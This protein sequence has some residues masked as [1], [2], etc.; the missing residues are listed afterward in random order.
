[1]SNVKTK[2]KICFQNRLNLWN[3]DKVSNF[4]KKKWSWNFSKNKKTIF[5]SIFFV[6]HRKSLRFIFKG[7]LRLRS[8]LRFSRSLIREKQFMTVLKKLKKRTPKF[9]LFLNK[10]NTRLDFVLYNTGFFSSI[11]EVRQVIIH[12]G[13]IVNGS[14]NKKPSMYLKEGFS[15]SLRPHIKYVIFKRIYQR[16]ALLKPLYDLIE[17]N[18]NTLS[19]TVLPFSKSSRRV[20]PYSDASKIG[21]LNFI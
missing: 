2:Y 19:I 20:V 16:Q 14:V 10:I 21:V 7:F 15:V 11:F 1:M 3:Q 12:G 9:F 5:S 8:L 6:E 4:R 17:I 18:Y 13:I